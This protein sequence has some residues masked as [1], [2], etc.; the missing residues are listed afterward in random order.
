LAR[1]E[2]DDV[3]IDDERIVGMP[4]HDAGEPLVE[5][6]IRT[7]PHKRVRNDGL[8]RFTVRADVAERLS[9]AD[10]G[11]ADA[12]LVL[13]EGHRSTAVQQR[14]WDH[15]WEAVRLAHPGWSPRQISAETARFVAPPEGNPPHSTGGAV[16]VILV[17]PQGVEI[18]MGS[19]LNDPCPQ[20]AMAAEVDATARRWREELA[21]AMTM[22]GFVNYPQEW[23]HFSFGDQ[24]WAWRTGAPAAL[25]GR[26]DGDAANAR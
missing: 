16:D 9:L 2:A 19:A 18:D 5:A 7:H 12:S 20:M 25:Y 4:V 3:L 22:A 26:I 13:V 23:W 21:A 17:D 8:T 6:A 15:R 1:T 10:A 24:Y 11:L 14:F